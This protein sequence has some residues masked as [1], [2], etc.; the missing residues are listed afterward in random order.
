LFSV[1]YIFILP[2]EGKDYGHQRLRNGCLSAVSY[3]ELFNSEID[4]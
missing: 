2:Q 4:K 3:I 1:N